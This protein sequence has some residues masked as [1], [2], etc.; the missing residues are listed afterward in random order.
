MRDILEEAPPTHPFRRMM[1]R[2]PSTGSFK[3]D[4][5]VHTYIGT[6]IDVDIESDMAVPRILGVP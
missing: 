1:V 3:E 2:F 5:Q 6:E 4:I